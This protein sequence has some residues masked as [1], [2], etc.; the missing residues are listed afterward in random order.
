MQNSQQKEFKPKLQNN[1]FPILVLAII[2]VIFLGFIAFILLGKNILNKQV[3]IAE[4]YIQERDGITINPEKKIQ[5]VSPTFFG[6]NLYW[7]SHGM[8]SST[9]GYEYASQVKTLLKDLNLSSYRF[10]GG[11][12]SDSYQ[13][14]WK[15]SK[16]GDIPPS[17][18]EWFSYGMGI[19]QY[20]DLS[21]ELNFTPFY[22]INMQENHLNPNNCSEHN[23]YPGSIEE[24]RELAQYFKTKLPDKKVFWELSNEPW[25]WDNWDLQTYV[26]RANLYIDAI[27]SVDPS[28]KFTWAWAVRDS[29]PN[30]EPEK[31]NNFIKYLNNNAISFDALQ[32][33]D[34]YDNSD[35]GLKVEMVDK[36]AKGR[37]DAL[38][39]LLNQ[40]GKKI[41]IDV[42]EYNTWCVDNNPGWNCGTVKHSLAIAQIIRQYLLHGIRFSHIHGAVQESSMEE[43]YLYNWNLLI[44][45]GGPMWARVNKPP[46][47]QPIYYLMKLLADHIGTEIV[48][49]ST[50]VENVDV[51]TSRK[52]NT[53]YT[54]VINKNN[55]IKHLPISIENGITLKNPARAWVVGNGVNPHE[56]TDLGAKEIRP[57]YV[58]VK[59]NVVDFYAEPYSVSVIEIDFLDPKAPVGF[60]KFDEAAGTV[61]ND[62]SGNSNTGILVNDLTWTSE[63]KINSAL[64]LDNIYKSIVVS[65]SD[66]LKPNKITISVSEVPLRFYWQNQSYIATKGVYTGEDVELLGKTEDNLQIYKREN[67]RDLNSLLLKNPRGGYFIIYQLENK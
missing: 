25:G 33:H 4:I 22:T 53:L 65:D 38:V 24:T 34:Y 31:W 60:W 6:V 52:D 11:C 28:A 67:Q 3:K 15:Q 63:G 36:E 47:K 21:K 30:K 16:T 23:E 19:D 39:N 18:N 54:L 59:N 9:G 51:L 46:K 48:E 5:D 1:K 27:K 45:G 7:V 14:K 32:F 40:T 61:A 56:L 2:V 64:Y 29:T 37:L 66:L 26:S 57:G 41:N 17:Y 49:S 58:Q 10:P 8:E 12:P 43:S 13:W 35:N 50:T 55:E 62:S 42:S 20:I 44:T